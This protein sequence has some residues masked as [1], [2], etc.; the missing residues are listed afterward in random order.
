MHFNEYL[1]QCRETNNFTQEKLVEALYNY[2][3]DSFQGL[4]TNMLSKWERRVTKPRLSKQVKILKFFQN[5]TGVAVP[6]QE[7]ETVK[8]VEALI[9]EIGM[10]NLL[11]KSKEL[12]LN[13]PSNIIGYDDLSVRQLRNTK[14]IDD[15]LEI[16]VTLDKDFNQ[17][18]TEIKTEHFHAWAL[19][20]SN[21]F[22]VC[23]FENQ[24]FGLLFT[25][26]LKPAS[27]EKIMNF[28]MDEKELSDDDFASYDEIGTSYLLSFFAMNDKAASMLFIRYYAYLI[29][30]QKVISDVGV[31]TMLD[32]AKKLIRNMNLHHYKSLN[33]KKDLKMHMY[34]ETLSNFLASEPVLKMILSKQ[35]CPEE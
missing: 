33:I 8:E 34:R 35:D 3:I 4:D 28:E 20:P 13:F 27:F 30:H 11:G 21:A 12:V 14:N 2:D 25:L 23:E 22:Y 31:A 5:K 18:F 26:R 16:N 32:D 7:K 17:N 6:C 1:K 29:A 19:H 15:I 24:F 10:H 9:C